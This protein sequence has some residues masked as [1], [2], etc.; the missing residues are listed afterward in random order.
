MNRSN[1]AVN[2]LQDP[3]FTMYRFS[4]LRLL[5]EFSAMK[6]HE[7]SL[8]VAPPLEEAGGTNQKHNNSFIVAAV[9]LSAAGLDDHSVTGFWDRAV[10]AIHDAA[11]IKGAN[12]ILLPEL[13][14]GPYFC[15]SQE[16]ALMGLA[17]EADNCFIVKNMQRIA[18]TY[19]VVLPISIFERKNNALFNS[20]VMIDADGT[21]LGTYRKSHIPDG[22]GYQ[23]KFYFSPGDTGFRVWKTKVGNVGVAICWDQWFPEAARAMA[24]QG[25]DILLYP[26]AIGSEPQDSSINSADHWQRVMQ[27]HAAANVRFIC[28]HTAVF[29]LFF[30]FLNGLLSPLFRDQMHR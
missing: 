5:K 7:S 13:F 14:L 30:C 22:T 26:T 16:A 20:I 3:Q 21:I 2:K 17:M 24:L 8:T 18:K 4:P 12:L 11:T 23:E 25:A 9:Q 6:A 19:K 29:I 1:K 28:R 10:R 27:G 15:Q